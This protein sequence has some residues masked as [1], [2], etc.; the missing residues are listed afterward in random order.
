MST[1]KATLPTFEQIDHSIRSLNIAEVDAKTLAD[2]P[3]GRLFKVAAIYRAF[4]PLLVTVSF[5]PLIP[6]YWR[7]VAKMFVVALD[8]LAADSASDEFKAGQDL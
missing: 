8:A 4:R 6:S 7:R 1:I 5:Y 3:A 2:A